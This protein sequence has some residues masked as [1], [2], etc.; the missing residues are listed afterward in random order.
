MS[1]KQ[2][3]AKSANGDSLLEV[4][5][6]TK[7]FPV[8]RGAIFRREVGKVR[9]VDGVTF[10]I[11]PN[12]TLGLVGES[13]CGKTTTGNAVLQLDPPTSGEVMFEGQNLVGLSLS[14]QRATRRRMQMIFQDPFGSLN[15]RMSIGKII[16][17]P[18][19]IHKIGESRRDRLDRVAE[20]LELVGLSS[21]HAARYPHEFS[22]GQRQRIALA[23]ALAVEPTFVVCDEPVSALDVSIQAQII[24]LFLD[25]QDQLGVAYLFIS[26]DLKVVRQISDRIAVMYLGKIV[27]LAPSAELYSH[28]LHPYSRA[29]LSA[30]PIPD[31]DI[32]ATR[33]RIILSGDVPSPVDPPTGCRFH[34]RCPWAIDRCTSEDPIEREVSG[35]TVA[36]HLAEEIEAADGV[37]PNP[38]NA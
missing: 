9:A 21:K 28:P 34:P 17:E 3:T 16:E 24:N 27:E 12:E 18:L 2:S 1:H 32:E 6:L 8:S 20:L 4:R 15:P 5:D 14:E 26:H 10:S 11:K 30:V 38:H 29:L 35:H 31:P 22:G 37:L 13:G 33:E 36:C 25:L 19:G 7:Y 23:R